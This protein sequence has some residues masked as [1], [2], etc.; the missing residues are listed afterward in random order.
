MNKVKATGFGG[1]AAAAISSVCCIGP[2]A[3]AGLG[4]G[5]GAIGIVQGFGVFHWPL[6]I[7]AALL[8]GSAFYFHYRGQKSGAEAGSCEAVPGGVRRGQVILWTAT[9]LTAFF[10]LL[11]Y[12]I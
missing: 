1:M 10:V 9:A 6:M 2:V 11:P 5:A 4:F 12:L 3:L 7:L 8:L